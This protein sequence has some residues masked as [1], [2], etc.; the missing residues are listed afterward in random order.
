MA[1]VIR[2]EAFLALGGFDPLY[3]FYN[4]DFDASNRIRASGGELVRVPNA[5]FDHGKGGRSPRGRLIREFWF[6]F[7]HQILEVRHARAPATALK[8]LMAVAAGRSPSTRPSATGR[9]P[10]A[11]PSPQ[12][13]CRSPRASPSGAAA[14]PGA[15]AGCAPGWRAPGPRV[16]LVA[17]EDAA[18]TPTPMG[19]LTPVPPKP[20]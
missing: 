4:E 9:A 17:L 14:H 16:Q 1:L 10:P 19:Q 8:H 6:A 18:G 3:F 13:C 7:T 5:R 2:R 12:R 15:N 11:S 20:Q